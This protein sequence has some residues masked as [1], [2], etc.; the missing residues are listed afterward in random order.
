MGVAPPTPRS[1]GFPY[2]R[3]SVVSECSLFLN[4]AGLSPVIRQGSNHDW[5][6]KRH[7]NI[8]S[9][10]GWLSLY[11]FRTAFHSTP[12]LVRNEK[13]PSSIRQVVH[14]NNGAWKTMCSPPSHTQCSYQGTASKHSALA[15][16]Q[17]TKV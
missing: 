1:N 3:L 2:P 6:A 9:I 10:Y 17:E 15:E 4:G 11:R 16:L 7:F 12:K 13:F 14:L 5:Q 8:S